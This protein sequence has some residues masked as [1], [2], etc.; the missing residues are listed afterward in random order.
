MNAAN[1]SLDYEKKQS[2]HAGKTNDGNHPPEV[3][4]EQSADHIPSESMGDSD[5]DE[6]EEEDEDILNF[7]NK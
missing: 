5:L 3:F 1:D 6:Y 4:N 7:N 2:S